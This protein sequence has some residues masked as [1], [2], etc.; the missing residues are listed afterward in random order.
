MALDSTFGTTSNSSGPLLTD[1]GIPA[2]RDFA[3]PVIESTRRTATLNQTAFTD[4]NLGRRL[5]SNTVS[6][7]VGSNL[8]SLVRLVTAGLIVRRLGAS[9][10]GEYALIVVWMTIAEWILDFG[11]TEVFVREAN[12]APELR[13]H[14]V[15]IFL[16]LKM[17]QA[18]LAVLVL[19]T[20]F[21]AMQYS[22]QFIL[23]GMIAGMSLFFIA[24]VALC[25]ATFK[26]TLTMRREVAAE[27]VSVVVMLLL[28]LLVSF[29]G[30]GLMGLMALYFLSR[31]VFLAG[32][33]VLSRGLIGLSIR[34]V[35]RRDLR[36]GIE[37]SFAIGV[38]G[39]VV[40]LY[41]AA[42]LLVVS[43]SASLSDV[44]VYSVAQRFT[45]PLTMALNAIAV[46]LYPV[47]ALLK[48]P[49]RFNKT[50]QDAVDT[51]VVLG[52]LALVCLWC[53]AE[54][55]MSLLGRE[56]VYGAFALRILAAMCVI[57]AVSMVIGPALFLVRAQGYALGYT[58][59]V[60]VLKVAV[61]APLALRFG[62]SGAAV[63]AL[64][65]EAFFLAPV[66][67]HYVRAFTGFK[68]RYA[69]IVRVA[70]VAAGVIMVTRTVLP[71]GNI[72][73]VTTAAFLYALL[74][75][76]LRIIHL[77]ELRTLLRRDPV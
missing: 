67:L 14:L 29:L 28:V 10:F 42:D 23:A 57:K 48:S 24:G 18:P 37:S 68:I 49:E 13:H 76:G 9:V 69:A 27:F 59:I 3:P 5:V 77:S 72:A 47:L 71:Q 54:F 32:C 15:K 12:Q 40:V 53:G 41:T 1:H 51:T 45:M 60:L 26:A 17:I 11:T 16:T 35:N 22:T 30:W 4:K 65:V 50:C 56:F 46:S 7:V 21:L 8:N 70:A 2:V 31:A 39:F 43:R 73:G 20:G 36:W 64:C 62:Y 66:T 52:G 58:V 19:L 44:A 63:G 75:L 38:I 6:L 74:V 61:I 55:C 34:G 25:R 33:L